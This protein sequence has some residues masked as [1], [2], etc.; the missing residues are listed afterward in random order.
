MVLADDADSIEEIQR[1]INAL[2]HDRAPVRNARALLAVVRGSLYQGE[3]RP[4]EYPSMLDYADVLSLAYDKL[5][6]AIERLPPAM[7]EILKAQ[8]LG[9]VARAGLL[10]DEDEDRS[11]LE[12]AIV[13]GV[14]IDRIDDAMNEIESRR[15]EFEERKGAQP[16][17]G[18]DE[19]SATER[20]ETSQQPDGVTAGRPDAGANASVH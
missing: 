6:E 16:S 12:Y 1:E 20:G 18:G 2:E 17:V 8:S 3:A 13:V 15:R 9:T 10:N 4:E 5:Q 11:L 19:S 14:A 7:G